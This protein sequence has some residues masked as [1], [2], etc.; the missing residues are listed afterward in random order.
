MPA[1]GLGGVRFIG[2]CEI[3][4]L[5]I[6]APLARSLYLHRYPERVKL[7]PPPGPPERMGLPPARAVRSGR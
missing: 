4:D 2:I 6:C 7:V 1:A 5:P 3:G